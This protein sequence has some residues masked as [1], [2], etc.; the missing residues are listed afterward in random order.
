MLMPLIGRPMLSTMVRS[1]CGG[2]IDRIAASIRPTSIAVSSILVPVGARTCSAICALS[3]GGKEIAPEIGRERERAA[4]RRQE[5]GDEQPPRGER[6][7]QQTPVEGARRL[8]TLLEA[9]P[10]ERKRIASSR[11]RR[12]MVVNSLVGEEEPRHRIHQRAREH[13]GRR[14]A[15]R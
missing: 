11:M 8:E 1:A 15:R 14:R 2:M 6:C 3:T 4:D 13:V 10:N 9:A 12:V 7:D 5:N